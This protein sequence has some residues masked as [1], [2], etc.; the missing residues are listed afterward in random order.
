MGSSLF[1][2]DP[3]AVITDRAVICPPRERLHLCSE[4]QRCGAF[5]SPKVVRDGTFMKLAIN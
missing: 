1:G 2:I 5:A 4:R 3:L